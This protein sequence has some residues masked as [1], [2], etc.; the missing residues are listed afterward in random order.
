MSAASR[1]SS[2]R[3]L[4]TTVAS[5]TRERLVPMP[6][7]KIEDYLEHVAGNNLEET[8]DYESSDSEANAR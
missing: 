4:Y 6:L 7:V 3:S 1:E 5:K 8:S 2:R